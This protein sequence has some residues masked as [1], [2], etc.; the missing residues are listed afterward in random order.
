MLRVKEIRVASLYLTMTT[1]VKARRPKGHS[2]HP[3]FAFTLVEVLVVI[4]ITAILAALLAISLSGAHKGS[5]KAT[6]EGNLRQIGIGIAEFAS[7]F[8]AYPLADNQRGF[9]QGLYP[10]CGLCWCDALNRNCFHLPPLQELENGFI[11]PPIS[12]VWHCPSAQRPAWDKDFYRKGW[13]WPARK[14]R[15][16]AKIEFYAAFCHA[17]SQRQKS[18]RRTDTGSRLTATSIARSTSMSATAAAKRYSR[19]KMKLNFASHLD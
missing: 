10:E 7:D 3:N 11:V 19:L 18:L 6:C 17:P 4:A 15:I 1:N 14:E 13:L 5:Q 8:N 12:G 9:S 2:G 16:Q